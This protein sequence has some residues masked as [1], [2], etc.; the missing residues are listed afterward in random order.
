MPLII[1]VVEPTLKTEAGHCFSFVSALCGA[2]DGVTLFR[3]WASRGA[4]LDFS[5]CTVDIRQHFSRRLRLL[6]GYFL[7]RRLLGEPGKLFISTARNTDLLM[8]GLAASGVIPPKKAYLYVHWLNASAGKRARLAALARKQPNLEIYAPT[9]SVAAVFREAGFG[10]VHVVPYPISPMAAPAV[11]ALQP[12]KHLLYAGAAR[13]DKGF[14]KVVDLVECLHRQGARIPVVL[15]T[16]AEQAGKM[17]LVIRADIER[18]HQIGYPHLDVRPDTLDAAQ[19]AD[20]FKGAICLQLYDANMFADRI[21]GVTLD[22]FSSGAP[23]LTTAGSWIA[24]MV[25]RF[26]AGVVV[27]DSAPVPLLATLERQIADYAL[28]QTRARAAG[29][30]LQHENS[31]STLYTLLTSER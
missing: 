9:P 8:L 10:Q 20:L 7:Y 26:E 22:A 25:Q 30:V 15:Q 27:D 17:D 31:A 24:R 19:Y 13:T 23:V 14:S 28:L 4:Q 12:F 29:E 16:S 5:G 6:Q 11:Q 2:S 18:L 21:S 3:V 1:N